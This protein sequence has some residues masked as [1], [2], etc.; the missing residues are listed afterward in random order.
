MVFIVTGLFALFVVTRKEQGQDSGSL[1]PTPTQT[2]PEQIIPTSTPG[3]VTPSP[4]VNAPADW[5]IYT[6]PKFNFALGYPKTMQ[7]REAGS[8]AVSF[9]L[10]G[11]TQGSA[12]SEIFDGFILTFTEDV[13]SGGSFANFVESERNSQAN[14]PINQSVSSISQKAVGNHNGLTFSVS[15][16]GDYTYLYFPASNN[17]YIQVAYI[18]A[19]PDNSGYQSTIDKIISTLTY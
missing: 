9:I 5:L 7:V 3:V 2:I 12:G 18:A 13:Y 15:G 16:F 14:D 19:D 8:K 6:S 10:L 4:K 17:S 11:P 1:S